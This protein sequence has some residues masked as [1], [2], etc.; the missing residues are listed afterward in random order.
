MTKRR[1]L[2]RILIQEGFV[3]VR[4]TGRGNHDKLKHPDGR[5]AVVERHREI[6][7]QVAKMVLVEVGIDPI[8]L[9]GMK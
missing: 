1:D 5:T 6:P 7:Y 2:I 8:A 4:G 9:K 3:E